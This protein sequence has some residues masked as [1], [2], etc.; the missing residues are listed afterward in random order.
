MHEN[1]EKSLTRDCPATRIPSGEAITLLQGTRVFITQALGGSFTVATDQG[2]ARIND[3]DA[4]ALGLEPTIAKPAAAA[5]DASVPVDEKAVWDQLRTCYDPEIPVNIV[6]LGLVYDCVI[7]PR[8]NAGAK[9]D[10]KMTLTA[11]GCGM[12]PTIAAEAKSKVLSVPGVGDAEVEL[13]WDPPWNQA[14]ISEVGKMKLGL[15]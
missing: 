5:T 6:D 2:L 12:G 7:S 9:V 15:I 14:M 10:V 3:D 13:V 1:T 11:P 8:E 4:D